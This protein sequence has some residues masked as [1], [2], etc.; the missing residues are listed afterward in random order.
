MNRLIALRELKTLIG[1]SHA[2]IYARMA[3][4][5]FPKPVK[6]GTSSRWRSKDIEDWIDQQV[7][8]QK[9]SE[10]AV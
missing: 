5:Q 7:A 10:V 4:G 3:E 9:S 2:W 6:V 8:A 1:F